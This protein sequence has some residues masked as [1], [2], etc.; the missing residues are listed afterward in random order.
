MSFIEGV[1]DE[2]V[3]FS[4]ILLVLILAAT[5]TFL[6]N[7]SPFTEVQTVSL[8]P[9]ESSPLSHELQQSDSDGTSE[10]SRTVNDV[11]VNPVSSPDEIEEE[12]TH[13][14]EDIQ[15]N[16]NEVTSENNQTTFNSQIYPNIN[17]CVSPTAPEVEPEE[18][19]IENE[20]QSSNP[21]EIHV[22]LKYL[23]DT[24][25]TVISH[26][27]IKIGDFKRKHFVEDIENNKIVRLIFGGQLLQ[28]NATLQSYGVANNCV[29]HVQIL[30]AQTLHNPSSISQNTDL[31]LSHLLWPLL[32]VI[33]GI[34]WILYLKYPEFFNFMSL[35]MLLL[36][37][38][39]FLYFYFQIQHQ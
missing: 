5:I 18:T 22:R 4:I 9:I 32:S 37:T 6:L 34:C 38:G 14:V 17:D 12:L 23:D 36:F 26:P 27:S 1:G 24:E 31:D 19:S 25:R 2:V 15:T 3:V 35:G 8:H 10:D 21:E 16:D 28:E 13:E 33:L 7:S 11:D 29:I 39:S 30:P 20:T